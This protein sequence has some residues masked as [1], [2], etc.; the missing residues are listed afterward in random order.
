MKFKIIIALVN[1]EITDQVVDAAKEAG[2]TGD[3]IIP[4]R[5]SGVK[6]TKSFFGLVIE[7]KTEMIMFLVEE[8]VV[9]K[10]LDGIKDKGEFSKPG[11]G[12]A[13]VMNVEQVAGLESQIDKYKDQARDSY[14]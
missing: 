4:A 12:I 13:F 3:V 9:D 6:E 5:G 2:A 8:H 7:D 1:P 14:L 11:R 10:I